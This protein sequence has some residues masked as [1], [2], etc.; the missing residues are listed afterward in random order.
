MIDET[1]LLQIIKKEKL[2]LDIYSK[3]H[4]LT[5]KNFIKQHW[6]GENYDDYFKNF[7]WL[8]T[9]EQKHINL[10]RNLIGNIELVGGLM[11]LF[12]SCII[13]YLFILSKKNI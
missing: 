11:L 9:E 8:M 7:K 3:I 4:Y 2:A 5:N 6:K 12:F 13:F 10:I 1:I